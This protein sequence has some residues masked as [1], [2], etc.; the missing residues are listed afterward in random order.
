[1]RLIVDTMLALLLIGVLGGI[2]WY[3]R[4]QEAWLDKVTA[5]QEALRAVESK[6]LYYGAL[7]DVDSTRQGYPLRVDTAWFDPLPVNLLFADEARPWMD[8]VTPEEADAFNPARIIAEGNV[9]AFWYNPY[10]GIVRARVPMQLTQGATIK[11]YNLVNGT[12]VRIEDVDWTDPRRLA[13]LQ[14]P[15]QRKVEFEGAPKV[16][17]ISDS[18]LPK[19]RNAPQPKPAPPTSKLRQSLGN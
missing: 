17:P 6:A 8:T 19:A 5:V 10:R 16:R 9:S 18:P 1:M 2:I 7:G 4:G 12:S 15:V 11:L 3:Q 13:Q 14:P